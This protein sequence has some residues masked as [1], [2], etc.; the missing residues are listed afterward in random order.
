MAIFKKPGGVLSANLLNEFE[1]YLNDKCIGWN[2]KNQTLVFPYLPNPKYP[3]PLNRASGSAIQIPGLKATNEQFYKGLKDGHDCEIKVLQAIANLSDEK[4]LGFK[5]FHDVPINHERLKLLAD[6]YSSSLGAIAEFKNGE[7]C[8]IVCICNKF[9]ALIEVKTSISSAKSS[10][11]KEKRPCIDGNSFLKAI[12]KA[13]KMENENL[14]IVHVIAIP[15]V[16]NCES[17]RHLPQKDYHYIC[18]KELDDQELLLKFWNNIIPIGSGDHQIA[19]SNEMI[20]RLI[21]SMVAMKVAMIKVLTDDELNDKHHLMMHLLDASV[22]EGVTGHE[23]YSTIVQQKH[24]SQIYEKQEAKAQKSNGGLIISIKS[25]PSLK[26]SMMNEVLFFTPEQAKILY[27]VPNP[28]HIIF[29]P[30]ASGKTLLIQAKA[31]QLLNKNFR[32]VILIPYALI[33]LYDKF[34]ARTLDNEKMSL[35]TITSIE[36]NDQF[37]SFKERIKIGDHLLIDEYFALLNSSIFKEAFNELSKIF[38]SLQPEQFCWIVLDPL[39]PA[40]EKNFAPEIK[41]A[42]LE[43][44]TISFLLTVQRCTLNVFNQWNS[45]C[46]RFVSIGHQY[47]GSNS[48]LIYLESVGTYKD[49]VDSLANCICECAGK[50]LDAGWNPKDIVILIDDSSMLGWDPTLKLWESVKSKLKIAPLGNSS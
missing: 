21:I 46:G 10:F 13:I 47:I 18:K 39:Q 17:I 3:G 14:N 32:V 43:N 30:A 23:I 27:H 24:L 29:G 34:F 16:E 49:R 20:E 50:Q 31:I 36:N 22:R 35:L 45:H 12:L 41:I 38:Q 11:V 6:A 28:K 40:D 48:Q 33:D 2:K 4:S 8:D 26:N 15:N 19:Q 9:I 37:K 7:M 44:A 25:D 5:L 42:G 1:N